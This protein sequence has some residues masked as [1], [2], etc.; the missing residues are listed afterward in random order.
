MSIAHLCSRTR[1]LNL[2]QA[3][4][5]TPAMVSL[6]AGF[7][8]DKGLEVAQHE[9]HHREEKR[10]KFA[11]NPMQIHHNNEITK[12]ERSHKIHTDN[13]DQLRISEKSGAFKITKSKSGNHD[14]YNAILPGME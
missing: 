11:L 5:A 1:R 14:H 10:K 4:T 8:M 13:I 12:A 6:H 3:F 7:E 9:K 2:N